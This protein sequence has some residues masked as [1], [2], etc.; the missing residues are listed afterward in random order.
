VRTYIKTNEANIACK[1]KSVN[2]GG[3]MGTPNGQQKAS[4]GVSR[5]GG[6]N[7]KYGA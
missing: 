6:W 2:N 1:Y 4:W 5:G 7:D 3:F